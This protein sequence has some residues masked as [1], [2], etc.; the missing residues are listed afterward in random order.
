LTKIFKDI[1]NFIRLKIYENKFRVGFFSENNF[2][3]EYLEPYLLRKIKKNRIMILSFESLHKPYID[4]ENI[5]VFKTKFFQ[6]LV[7]LTLKLKYLYSSTPDLNFTI[8]KK[9]KNS[10]CKYIYLSHTPVSMTLIYRKNSFDYFD[11]V[12]VTND[13]QFKEM[14]EIVKKN[15][16]KTKIFKSKYLFIEKQKRKISSKSFPWDLLIAP[17]WNS[18]FY[19]TKSHILLNDLLKRKDLSFRLRP[20]PMSYKKGEI[21]KE[22]LTKLGITI[23]DDPIIDFQKYDFLISDWSGIFIEYSLIFKKKAFLINTPKKMQNK[24]Y[25]E[26]DNKPIEIILR[27][28][29]ANSYEIS[30]IPKIV[31]NIENLK[32]TRKKNNIDKNFD[33]ILR[34]NFY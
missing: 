17:S 27:N 34:N 31:Q 32:T 2:I 1:Y 23:D 12:Q 11:A 19:S 33:Q 16:L 5:F 22:E 29:L 24:N 25:D 28:T 4:K 14:K 7:F 21:T 9:S 6:E 13:Y 26:F 30:E 15:G 20:H 10:N 3:Y 8:F 18:S